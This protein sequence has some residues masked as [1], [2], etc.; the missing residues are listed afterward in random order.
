M[1]GNGGM[2]TVHVSMP[3]LPETEEGKRFPDVQR[4]GQGGLAGACATAKSH[5]F[6]CRNETGRYGRDA[7]NRKLF[8]AVVSTA[9]IKGE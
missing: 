4:F 8:S 5:G 6:D 3:K 9:N 1:A 7:E 2:C